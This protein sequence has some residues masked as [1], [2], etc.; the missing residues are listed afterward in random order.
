MTREE[1]LAIK[2][3]DRSWDGRFF[4]GL[5]TTKTVCRPSCSK[6]TP[7]PRNVILFS[8][9]D[10]AL[11]QGYTP[12]KRCRPEQSDWGGSKKELALSAKAYIEGH[13]ME[14]FS[15]EHLA[16]T[17]FINKHYLLRTFREL[18]GTTLLAYHNQVRCEAAKELLTRPELTMSYIS[19]TVGFSS[20]SHFSHVFHKICGCTPSEYREEYMKS[21]EA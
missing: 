13:Y 1:W 4:Y 12:C 16:D 3:R 8:T 15:L 20:A 21:L 7:N 9:L 19:N 5:R 18:T 11:A 17:L 14:K 2:N 10:E 6:R